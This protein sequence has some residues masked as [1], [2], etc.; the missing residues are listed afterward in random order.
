MNR[1]L[2][3][4]SVVFAAMIAAT[5]F[6]ARRASADALQYDAPTPNPFIIPSD[7][8]TVD[9]TE[10]IV[11][12]NTYAVVIEDVTASFVAH[13]NEGH[14]KPGD[15]FDVVDAVHVDSGPGT[16]CVVGDS[17]AADDGSCTVEL[18]ITVSGLAPYIEHGHANYDDDYGD[19]NIQVVVDSSRPDHPNTNPRVDAE[20]VAQV[21]YAPEP[22]SLI[23]LG[24]GLLGL[25]GL[26]G[27]KR[28]QI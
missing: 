17:I 4:K 15:P 8:G 28:R 16:T 21:D 18:A 10:T 14:G 19:N 20:F 2:V 11:N 24:T 7:A 5:F 1:V 23:L 27:W 6:V 12:P 25:A 9:V 22:G 13:N 3:C 26:A